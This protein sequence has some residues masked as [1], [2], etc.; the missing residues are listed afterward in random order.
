M[1][2]LFFLVKGSKQ[3][4]TVFQAWRQKYK[5]WALQTGSATTESENA[6]LLHTYLATSPEPRSV[7]TSS[8]RDRK[9]K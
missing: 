1:M 3:T 8:V 9:D 6:G 2:C 5:D 7:S 4:W